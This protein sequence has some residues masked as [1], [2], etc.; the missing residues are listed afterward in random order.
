MLCASAFALHTPSERRT[1]HFPFGSFRWQNIKAFYDDMGPVQVGLQVGRAKNIC[2]FYIELY[3]QNRA[4]G[5]FTGDLII[6][7]YTAGRV[8]GFRF[9]RLT[10][11]VNGETW[12]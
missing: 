9:E 3:A 7:C 12:L 6:Q 1:P 11:G 2:G 4:S 10:E 8:D 5:H